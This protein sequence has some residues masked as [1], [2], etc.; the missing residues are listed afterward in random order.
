MM[1][2]I[3]SD[4][5]GLEDRNKI[6][7]RNNQ[8]NAKVSPSLIRFRPIT[9]KDLEFL[10]RVYASTRNEEMAVTGWRMEEMDAFL[11]M[12]FRLQHTQYL[13]NNPSA[14]F[15]VILVDVTPAGRLYVD[16]KA[17]KISVID[18]AL[19][20][21]FRQ[22]GVGGSIMRK[23]A[24]EADAKGLVMCLHVEM[25]NPI[26]GFYKKLG[27]KTK[28]EHGIYHYMEREQRDLMK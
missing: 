27:F 23:L 5:F 21:E 25:N 20:P 10:Y 13:Q 12:Q 18:I 9:D 4:L 19:L 8:M 24:E 17:D 22:R 6:Q 2:I 3:S 16:R 28:G 15:D 1:L 11:R 14:S 7:H 26:S